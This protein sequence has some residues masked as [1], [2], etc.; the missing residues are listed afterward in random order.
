VR[1]EQRPHPEESSVCP[2][3]IRPPAGVPARVAAEPDDRDV[4][5]AARR[6]DR[7]AFGVLYGRYARFVQAIVLARVAVDGADDIVQDVFV[8]AME[9]LGTLRHGDAFAPW[10]ATIARRRAADWRRRRRDT[11]ELE[12]S[13]S[14]RADDSHDRA[15]AR[16]ALDAISALPE[17]YRETLLLRLVAGLSGPEIAAR[18]GLT[19]G[20]VRVNLHRGIAMLRERLRGHASDA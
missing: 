5:A 7:A 10:I 9:R 17:A 2:S 14:A 12:E 4:V 11:V 1:P 19:P 18:T 15:A 6:G 8:T 3:T 13:M 20:S 16:E